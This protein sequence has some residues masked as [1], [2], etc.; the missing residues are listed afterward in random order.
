[1]VTTMTGLTTI[2]TL[3][4]GAVPASLITAG[5][6]G[7][8]AYVFD[9]TVSGITTL[10]ATAIRVSSD[11]AGSIGVSG[12]AFSDLFLA[13]GAVINFS[14]GD[15]TVTHSANT[16][17]LAGGT[18]V[19]GNFESAA[20]TATTGNFSGTTTF[21]TITYTWPA[22]DGGAGNVLSTNGSGILSWT[23]GGAGALGGSGTA[24]TIAKWSAAAT[25]TDSIL[26]ETASLITIAGGLDLSANLDLNTNNI[27]AG[28]TASF[29][30][31]TVT[32]SII[33]ASDVSA[34]LFLVE[35]QIF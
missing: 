8:G 10:T 2:G 32:N 28:G 7:T 6:F 5:T 22:S 31:L 26:T 3:I 29:T 11:N 21:N 12:T 15:I 13:S 35:L 1:S 27:T 19:V 33:R 16:L 23:A 9:N 30:T 25:F 34:L 24:G 4:A 18:F 14:S 20:L 17:T